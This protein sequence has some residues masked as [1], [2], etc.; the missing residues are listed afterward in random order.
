LED[1][2]KCE[3]ILKDIRAV[4]RL[5]ERLWGVFDRKSWLDFVG[6]VR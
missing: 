3:P 2:P 1:N 4:K 6:S 5:I